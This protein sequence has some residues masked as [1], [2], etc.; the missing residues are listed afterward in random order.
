VGVYHARA[1]MGKWEE[2][3]RVCEQNYMDI[4]YSFQFGM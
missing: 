4:F 2:R 3:S 1:V